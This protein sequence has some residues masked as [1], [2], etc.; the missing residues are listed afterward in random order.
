MRSMKSTK[1]TIKQWFH[2]SANP[3]TRGRIWREV[4][5]AQEQSA[6]TKSTLILPNLWKMIMRSPLTKL[7]TAAVMV[8]ATLPLVFFFD[9]GVTP[10]Y[11]LE[12]TI[13]ANHAIKTIYLRI[14]EGDPKIEN[15]EFTDCWIK[16]DDAGL[17]SNFRCD[18]Y[19]DESEKHA[20]A[21]WNEGVLKIW[22]P[23]QNTVIIVRVNDMEK[24]WEDFAKEYDPKLVFQWLYVSRGNQA[25]QLHIDKPAEDSHSIYVTATNSIDKTRLKLVIDPQTKLVKKLLK[26][27]LGEKEDKLD[28]QIDVLAYNQ[29]IDPSM[30][31]LSGIPDDALVIDQIDQL[32]GLEQGN[33]TNNEIVVKVVRE[34]LEATIAKDYEKVSRLMEGVP[35]HTVEEFIREEF[36]ARL[37][38]VTS[39]G[40]PMPH[41]R[42]RYH[43]YVPCEIE[44]E[45][46]ERGKWTV[47][48]IAMTEL[49][50]YQAGR[51]WVMHRPDKDNGSHVPSNDRANA[52]DRIGDRIIVPGEQVGGFRL[53]IDKDDMLKK[54]GKPKT[55]FLGSENYTLNNLP[56]RF[57]MVYDDISFSIDDDIVTGIAAHS[58]F[59][60]FTNGLGVGDSEQKIRQ[61]FG[62]DFHLEEGKGKDFL[63]YE[64][65]GLSFEINKEDR[66]VM[67][68]NVTQAKRN[69]EGPGVLKS[70]PKYDPNSENPFQ[71]DLRGRD[72][73]K[74]DLRASLE[75]LIY[76]NFDDKTVWPAPDR[77]PSGFDWQKI[78]ELGKNPGL[79]VRSLHEKGITGRGVRI[80][81]LDQPL[82][83]DHQEYADR[84]RLYEEIDLQGREEPSMHGAAVASIAVGKTVGI[85]PEAELYYIAKYNFDR[86]GTVTMRYIA[87]GI[88]R[89]LEINKQLPKDNKIRVISISR[90]WGP[91]DDGY[92]DV[93]AACEEA[94]AAGIFIVSCSIDRVY[95][96]FVFDGLGR[97]P[98]N[99][100]DDFAS[101]EPGLWLADGFYRGQRKWNQLWIPMDSRATASPAGSDEYVFY[102]QGGWSWSVPY[103]AGVYVLAAQVDP[104]ITPERF[105]KLAMKTGCTIE[106]EHQ[107]R[108][109]ELG[110]IVDPGA[111]IDA[112]E[113]N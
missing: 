111:L 101:Y 86:K 50:D 33:L 13:E 45:N 109:Y 53:G 3:E 41:E 82:L 5:Q 69:S 30:F 112:L 46:K 7:T 19:E 88:N 98:L 2:V 43:I 67:E 4:L 61:A 64:D 94:K 27:R 20:Y 95:H 70:L 99:N 12:Q 73:S 110:P 21:V 84:V 22:R 17:V 108:K 9:R 14:V 32:V 65:R 102:R 15:N 103:I 23:S 62:N 24:Y 56:R 89:I 60:K 105:W 54:L 1:E 34:T 92:D 16:Y 104:E 57:F 91:S 47:N 79:G 66:T 106:V 39:I 85:A 80:A 77:M 63:S 107:G 78:V 37:V 74:L 8:V 44:V 26:Y 42:S 90:G 36:D 31:E 49:V 68:I 71:V 25:N 81:I 35:G 38:G 96:G 87:Q 18:I 29:S 113:D 72:L 97:A 59:Y 11:A 52:Q 76:A 55:I 100:P 6:K 51:R 48:I 10:V 58:P 75:S 28:T 83:V 40:Q 93:M